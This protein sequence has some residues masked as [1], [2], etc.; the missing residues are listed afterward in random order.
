MLYAQ[1]AIA[2]HNHLE[3][4]I[5]YLFDSLAGHPRDVNLAVHSI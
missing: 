2:F 5:I 4:E 1:I 3:I